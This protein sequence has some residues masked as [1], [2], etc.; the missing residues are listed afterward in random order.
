MWTYRQTGK[1][2]C[3]IFKRSLNSK[4]RFLS[5]DF[6]GFLGSM[7]ESLGYNSAHFP[8]IKISRNVS[9]GQVHSF[10]FVGS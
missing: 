4:E 1:E 5:V 10:V 9:R 7:E 6:H 3:L 2:N 8:D